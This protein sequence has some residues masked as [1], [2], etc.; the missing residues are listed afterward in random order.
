MVSMPRSIPTTE[1]ARAASRQMK[2]LRLTLKISVSD[3]ARL[4]GMKMHVLQARELGRTPWH[5]KEI[6]AAKVRIVAHQ[7][8]V[9][10]ALDALES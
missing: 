1:T 5:P 10:L 9:S 6:A 7:N 2:S 3:F 8:A 4:L